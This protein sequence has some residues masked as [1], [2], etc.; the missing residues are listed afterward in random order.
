MVV[1]AGARGIATMAVLW[2][3]TVSLFANAT[4]NWVSG[5]P[6]PGY[7]TGA[8]YVNGYIDNDAQYHTPSGLAIDQTGNYLLVADRNNNAV[9]ILQFDI[10]FVADFATFTNNTPASGLFSKPVGV[11]IDNSY[12]VFVLN[13]GSG[14]NGTVME[15]DGYGDLLGTNLTQ[16]TN[17]AGL[18]LDPSDNIYVTAGNTVVR[19]SNTGI[20]STVATITNAGTSLQGI[21]VKHNGL[22]AVCDAGRNG[23]LLIDPN[24]GLVTTNA[25]FHGQGD[26]LTIGNSSPS[27]QVRFFQ[28]TGIA[29]AG[30]GT[31]IVS[32][33]GNNRVKAVLANG[34][35]NNIYGVSSNYWGGAYPGFTDG[36]VTIPDGPGGVA[37]REP[38]GVVFGPDGTIYVTEDYYHIIRKVTGSGLPL[39]PP[40]PPAAPVIWNVTSNAAQVTLSWYAVTTA[41]N[42]NVKRSPSSLGPYTTIAQTAATTYADTSVSDGTAYYYVVSAVNTG[43]ESP[44]SAEVSAVPPIPPPQAPTIGWFDYEGNGLTGFVTVIHQVSGANTYTANNDLLL[45]VSPAT[46]TGLATFYIDGPAPLTN[47]P[48]STNGSTPPPYEDGLEY[49]KPLNVAPEPKLVIKA[50]SVG[51]GGSSPVTTAEFIFRAANPTIVGNNAAQ[52]TVSDITTNV[53]YWY[54]IDGSD[55]TNSAPS[56]GPIASTNGGPVTLS[57]DGSTNVLFKVRAFRDGYEPSGFAEQSFS[58]TA[59]VPNSISFGFASGEASSDFVGSP[60]QTF[61]A[62]VTLS[63]LPGQLIYS[64]QFNITVTNVG[65][66]AITP[67]AFEFQS[68]LEQS[69]TSTNT[70]E[71]VYYVIPPL[72]YAAYTAG[73]PP[74]ELVTNSIGQV[75]ANLNIP[76]PALNLLGVGWVEHYGNTNLYNTLGQDLIKYSQ[77]HDDLFP[78][79]KQPNGVIVGG[80][81]FTIPSNATNG[82]Q[83]QIQIGRPSATAD[84][85]GAP[86]ESVLIFAPTN[87]SLAGGA[88]NAVKLVTA[89]Q[90]RYVAGDAYPFRWFN[91]GDFG[92]GELVTNGSADVEQVFESAAYGWNVPPTNTDFYDCMDSSGHYGVYDSTDGYYTNG[93]PLSLSDQMALFNITDPTAL[94]TNMFGDGVLDVSDCYVTFI[95]SVDSDSGL[96]WIQ[97]FWTNGIRAALPTG[98]PSLTK[99]VAMAT[100]GTSKAQAITTLTSITNQPKVNFTA[101][102]VQGSANQT[103]Q[104]PIY[105]NVLGNYP[106]RMLLLNLT[107]VPLDGS[108]DLITPVS[109]ALNPAFN[110]PTDYTYLSDSRG[111]GNYSAMLLPVNPLAQTAGFTGNFLVG[112][113]TVTIP[114]GATGLS[115]YAI[116]FDSASASPN[117]LASFPKQALTGLITLS[118]RN[119]SSYGDGIPDSWRLRYFGTTNNLLSAASADA[120]GDGYS[121]W[122]EYVAGTDP[123][124][125]TSKLVAGNDQ[126]A[127]QQ[128]GDSV[129]CWPSVSGKQYVIQRSS[130]LFP[131]A[132]TSIS[133]NSGTGGMMEI[134]DLSGGNGRFYRVSVQ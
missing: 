83:Y 19:V 134:H 104:I 87:G 122:K 110:V 8:G 51:P 13:Y 25:G 94:N 34:S 90:R 117:G 120:D 31:L 21:V 91:A 29:E 2:L 70:S 6:S 12:N 131:P 118:G 42:Y 22:L 43:G 77:A 52:F 50:V 67:G 100:T 23:I 127:A 113:L 99:A 108:P 109:F 125:P 45:A 49:A 80:Y 92:S 133:T 39:A 27:N 35:V 116:H 106:V 119:T 30:D 121:N 98:N 40:P 103:V 17:A 47:N 20:K 95:R 63:T 61:Y 15:F 73:V 132:W 123:T 55:P 18:A 37:A 1:D 111:A 102:D 48:S 16:I 10:N 97:R 79:P 105:A 115:A 89:G 3:T 93:G 74:S 32:D 68:M 84:G 81:G 69:G 107:V 66:H 62:P 60:G 96:N 124:D 58:P 129:V 59:F 4:V 72:M 38:N 54:T 71:T 76:D 101:S 11:A 128:P 112:T 75:F 86:G 24:T 36:T 130:T 5:G 65:P 56:V 114:A 78:N 53:T 88:I 33:Y 26:F 85:I 64:L 7:P 46:N 44:N 28:P 9:R 41:T 82:E 57:L 14:N 126:A